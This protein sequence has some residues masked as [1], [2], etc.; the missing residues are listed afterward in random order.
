[1]G[2]EIK[3]HGSYTL[4][5][6]ELGLRSRGF[7][8]TVKNPSIQKKALPKFKKGGSVEY[9]TSGWQLSPERTAINFRD[10]FKGG[11][12]KM[13]DGFD[14]NFYQ[15]NQIKRIRVIRR[16]DGYYVQFCIDQKRFEE[17]KA[18]GNVIGSD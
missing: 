2:E 15:L 6:K 5:S 12:F 18:S 17:M 10:V 11:W 9:K 16:A 14:L 8:K 4:V 7:T 3:L 1:M 13:R